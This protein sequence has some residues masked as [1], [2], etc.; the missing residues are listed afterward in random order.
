MLQRV[1]AEIKCG[2]HEKIHHLDVMTRASCWDASLYGLHA[3]TSVSRRRVAISLPVFLFYS[4]HD[5]RAREATLRAKTTRLLAA[6]AAELRQKKAKCVNCAKH[7]ERN[8]RTNIK[9]KQALQKADPT[10]PPPPCCS[11]L[12]LSPCQG[13]TC[14]CV[15]HIYRRLVLFIFCLFFCNL[16]S[17]QLFFCI[18]GQKRRRRQREGGF[19]DFFLSTWIDKSSSPFHQSY[20]CSLNLKN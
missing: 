14:W 1:C 9:N 6:V 4:N 11:R 10:Q 3:C 13:L 8:L 15:L 16:K 17:A 5:W 2:K 19:H 7:E 12:L 20:E 18:R